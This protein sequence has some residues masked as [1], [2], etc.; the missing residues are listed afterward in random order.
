MNNLKVIENFS[1]LIAP[2]LLGNEFAKEVLSLQI[3]TIP[4]RGERFNVLLVGDPGT[5]KSLLGKYLSSALPRSRYTS[6][7]ITRV[8]FREVLEYA[9]GGFIFADELDK[10]PFVFRKALL[11]AMQFGTTTTDKFRDH[12][13]IATRVNVCGMC[14]PHGH[15][16]RKEIP[17]VKQLPFTLA[18]ATRYHLFVPF[19]EVD[20]ALYPNIAVNY[21]KYDYDDIKLKLRDY[22]VKLKMDIPEVKINDN[23]REEIG[24]FIR[25][26][27]EN[28]EV[29]NI[30][31]PRAIEGM[32]TAIKSRARMRLRSEAKKEDYQYVKEIFEKF[33]AI[34]VG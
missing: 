8:G 28:A 20:P 33:Y 27:K 32:L 17:L 4:Q 5:G 2:Q 1:D 12:G 11:E 18:E 3:L 22:I 7:D 34:G 6:D 31:S 25:Y 15:T 10:I 30:I 29:R 24:N 14:N 21:G 9:D 19:Y 23:I 16:L 13:T 26:S